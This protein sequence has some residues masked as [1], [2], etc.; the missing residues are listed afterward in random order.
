MFY[1]CT[2]CTCFIPAGYHGDWYS[3]ESGADIRT[4]IDVN[5]WSRISN[6]QE[7]LEC[8]DIYRHKQEISLLKQLND[9]MHN[10][11]MLMTVA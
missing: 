8:V 7:K 2:E 6:P 1:F 9:T 11:T 10:S 3:Q 4:S 5:L